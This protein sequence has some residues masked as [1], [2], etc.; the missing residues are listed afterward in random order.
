MCFVVKRVKSN[1]RQI[2]ARRATVCFVIIGNCFYLNNN[3]VLQYG[4]PENVV[5]KWSQ[6]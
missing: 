4:E 6:Y 1:V 2:F 3:G 5:S